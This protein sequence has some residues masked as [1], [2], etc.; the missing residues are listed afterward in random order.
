MHVR[1]VRFT[2]VTRERVEALRARVEEAGGPPPGVRTT[3][4]TVLFDEAQGTAV[5]L[6]H[7]DT[8]QDMIDGGKVF[9]AMEPG[10]TPGTRASVDNCETAIQ[11]QAP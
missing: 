3:A 1:V 11:V 8:E 4:L 9:S 2:D 10:E 6:Q 5:V 7:F